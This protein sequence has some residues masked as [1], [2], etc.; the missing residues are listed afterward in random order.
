MLSFLSLTTQRVPHLSGFLRKVGFETLSL[1]LLIHAPPALRDARTHAC[2]SK[3]F[4]LWF[5]V[6]AFKPMV[7]EETSIKQVR[8]HAASNPTLA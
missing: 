2:G 5:A 3:E 8:A 1:G 4:F 7:E 6:Q